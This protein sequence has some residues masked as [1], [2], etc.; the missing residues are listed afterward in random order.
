MKIGILTYH[1]VC[2]F[3][4]N[5]QV[6]STVSFIRKSGHTPIVIN[7]LTEELDFQYSSTTIVEQYNIHKDYREKYLPLTKR[8]YTDEDIVRT[9]CEEDIDAIIV[10]SDAVTQHHP[11]LSRIVFPCRK[12]ITIVKATK[13]R[14]CPN[15]FWGSFYNKLDKKIPLVMMSGSSQNSSFKLLGRKEK[16][17]LKEHI[18]Q[19]SYVSTRDDWTSKMINY[20]TDGQITPKVTPDPVFAFNAN[21]INEQI[22][23]NELYEKFNLPDKYF[24]LSFHNSHNVSLEWLSDFEKIANQ[25]GIECIALPFPNGIK[26]KHPF[27][28]SIKL[29]LSPLEWYA[30]I[31]YSQGYIGN[32]MHPIVVSLHNAI[33]CF[34]FDNYGIIKFRLYVNEKSSKIFHIMKHFGVSENRVNSLGFGYKAPTPQFVFNKLMSY[35]K[36]KIKKIASIFEK[37]YFEMMDNIFKVI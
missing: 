19:F 1:A 21:V 15:P 23:K 33:P 6:L 29:P 9:I 11:W 28:R 13:D 3:G 10:G 22:S 25:N 18:M 17:M 8:C 27:R 5:L 7:W 16:L 20:I 36:K 35:D 14:M 34:C 24:V 32:N 31:K 4:A 37:E 2:N 26:Y 12:I 30:I